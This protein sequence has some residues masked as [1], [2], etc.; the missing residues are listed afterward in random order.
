MPG[1]L[2]PPVLLCGAPSDVAL[3][4]LSR[5]NSSPPSGVD[6]PCRLLAVVACSAH[7]VQGFRASGSPP[8]GMDAPCRLLA[9]VTCS[10]HGV[11]GFRA[12]GSPPATGLD[13]RLTGSA[14]SHV[15]APCRLLAIVACVAHGVAVKH[16]FE[17][18]I[19][20]QQV[21]V[22]L[23][24]TSHVSE[25][26]RAFQCLSCKCWTVRTCTKWSYVLRITHPR[27]SCRSEHEQACR[28]APLHICVCPQLSR[29]APGCIGVQARFARAGWHAAA[30]APAARAARA[31]KGG[32][33]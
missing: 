14:P 16:A 30:S 9:V 21:T 10:A 2:W 5:W 31:A 8:A 1:V 19:V 11:Q 27:A 13:Y 12:S 20:C 28:A 18:C 17:H 32:P 24:E 6:A 3:W 29:G 33:R 26:L 7:G 15:N 25:G 23:Q 22:Q 4:L